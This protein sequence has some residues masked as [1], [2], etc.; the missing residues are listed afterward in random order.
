MN[1]ILAGLAAAVRLIG[2]P[3]PEL[4]EISARSLRVT[5]TAT[6]TATPIATA[7]G[8]PLGAWLAISRFR[9]RRAA[10]A[11]LTALMGLPLVIVGLILYEL[12]SRSGPFGV[13]GPLFTPAVP[14]R[15]PGGWRGGFHLQREAALN[16][17]AAIPAVVTATVDRKRFGSCGKRLSARSDQCVCWSPA[18]CRRMEHW[19][20]SRT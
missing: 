7:N 19:L 6:L 12:L 4:L 13:F 18:P 14:R 5:L 3:D 15:F 10:I 20:R 17:P 16:R 11:T 2:G 8:L 9:Q 1:D